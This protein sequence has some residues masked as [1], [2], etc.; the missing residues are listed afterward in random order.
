MWLRDVGCVGLADRAVRVTRVEEPHFD[1]LTGRGFEGGDVG[2]QTERAG[3]DRAAKVTTR[4][5]SL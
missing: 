5:T 2:L 1:A 3:P 4:T